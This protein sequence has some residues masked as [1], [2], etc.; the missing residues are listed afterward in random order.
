M[1]SCIS[2]LED[3][4]KLSSEFDKSMLVHDFKKLDRLIKSM[5]RLK[6]ELDE[7]PD[8]VKNK[9]TK[10]IASRTYILQKFK[11]KL[12]YSIDTSRPTIILFHKGKSEI[13]DIWNNT[14]RSLSQKLNVM[15][16]DCSRKSE[17]CRKYNVTKLPSI[18]LITSDTIYTFNDYF[19]END[20]LK[21]ANLAN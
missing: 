5:N 21:F 17:L 14:E 4:I 10:L 13:S 15:S 20:L 8:H 7:C 18:K 1:S 11:Y 6:N 9:I 16:I 3:I 19:T 12:K 2:T